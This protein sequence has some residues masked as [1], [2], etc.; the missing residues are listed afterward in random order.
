MTSFISDY[1]AQTQFLNSRA[2]SL[3]EN[4]LMKH[5]CNAD[6][7]WFCPLDKITGKYQVTTEHHTFGSPTDSAPIL[8]NMMTT[9]ES[10]WYQNITRSADNK[11]RTYSSIKKKFRLEP[12]IIHTG[13]S[14]CRNITQLRISCHPLV[15]ET[16]RYNK[17]KTPLDKDYLNIVTGPNWKRTSY[18]FCLP[19]LPWRNKFS[20]R[21][22]KW[23][24]TIK[25]ATI[26]FTLKTIL[27]M[28]DGDPDFIN[29]VCSFV[30]VCFAKKIQS[31]SSK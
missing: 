2:I 25:L 10:L 19:I 8:N 5:A 6:G 17:P 14:K 27:T 12:Y 13:T 29:P 24:H 15:V 9:Y 3:G 30:D 31:M 11:L 26:F 28:A 7:S 21:K 22:S 16:G 23:I 1:A 20:I 4:H 18:D